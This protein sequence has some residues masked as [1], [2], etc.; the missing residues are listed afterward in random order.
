MRL[1]ESRKRKRSLERKVKN[2]K[3]ERKVLEKFK[4]YFEDLPP[5]PKRR[6]KI[7]SDNQSYFNFRRD[8]NYI[9]T[10]VRNWFNRHGKNN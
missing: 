3:K 2:N 6:N 4:L 8:F 10:F 5:Q 7:I 1:K 9:R